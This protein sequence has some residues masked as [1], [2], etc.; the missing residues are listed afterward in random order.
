MKSASVRSIR[1]VPLLLSATLVAA[2]CSDSDNVTDQVQGE[3]A[4]S[5]V[6]VVVV[7]SDDSLNQNTLD[8]SMSGLV[9][10]SPDSVLDSATGDTSSAASDDVDGDASSAASDGATDDGL[11]AA[12]DDSDGATSDASD[13]A[14]SDALDGAASDASDGAASDASDS[15]SSE[16]S[17]SFTEGESEADSEGAADGSSDDASFE[18]NE[19]AAPLAISV[20]NARSIVNGVGLILN[21]LN[22]AKQIESTELGQWMLFP[23]FSRGEVTDIS[24]LSETVISDGP[25]GSLRELEYSCAGGGNLAVRYFNVD[26]Q[27]DNRYEFTNCFADGL[28]LDG[29]VDNSR[30][31][32]FGGRGNNTNYE[33]FQISSGSTGQL[34]QSW[35]GDA[36]W[37]GWSA[38][39]GSINWDF[40]SAQVQHDDELVRLTDYFRSARVENSNVQDAQAFESTVAE[41]M[42]ADVKIFNGTFGLFSNF[43]VNASWTNNVDMTVRVSLST[44]ITKLSSDSFSDD[45][46]YPMQI[47]TIDLCPESDAGECTAGTVNHYSVT[48]DANAIRE[49]QRITVV[50]ESSDGTSLEFSGARV[51]GLD[52]GEPVARVFATDGGQIQINVDEFPV[53]VDRFSVPQW[54]LWN[55]ENEYDLWAVPQ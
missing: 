6:T 17:D 11:S 8:D 4:D 51:G 22:I 16:E 34:L 15:V 55:E 14:T 21:D 33:D 48:Q 5:A 2:G 39:E 13:G 43:T 12:S 31:S 52:S 42:A 27:H 54:I 19:D 25:E 24:L 9:E 20:F 40:P 41:G 36:G 32:T 1:F 26:R 45:A 28:Q 53:F 30:F 44:D 3:L 37:G 29:V 35:T 47:S 7:D 38:I 18:I 49:W 50:V 46:I 10:N 23:R